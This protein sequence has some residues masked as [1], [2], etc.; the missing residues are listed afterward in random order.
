MRHA[1]Y[2]LLSFGINAFTDKGQRVVAVADQTA[3][4]EAWC[5]GLCFRGPLE[6]GQIRG[7]FGQKVGERIRGAG[8]AIAW[9]HDVDVAETILDRGL[10]G[11]PIDPLDETAGKE[12][13][14]DAEADCRNRYRAAR[15]MAE[16]VAQC[17]TYVC[18]T[19]VLP[20]LNDSH[21]QHLPVLRPLSC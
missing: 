19:H 10:P 7:G 18:C 1:A 2:E 12:E 16:S 20:D 6:R 17:Q 15:T 21:R 11:R 13:R 5:H 9:S 4:I 14:N 8:F 3:E